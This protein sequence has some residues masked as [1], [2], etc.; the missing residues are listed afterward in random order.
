MN[1]S[2]NFGSSW[3]TRTMA[4]FSRR[5]MTH[6]VIVTAVAM[7]RGCPFRQLSPKKSPVRLARVLL[8][9]ANFGKEGK[10]ETVIAKISQETLA[11]MVGTTRSR[12][13]LFM[14]EFRKLGF[15]EYNGSLEVHNSLLNVV[16]HDNPH[17]RR[18]ADEDE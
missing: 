16:L 18:R 15:I 17:L 6:S 11:E 4:A 3:S 8:L 9:L 7:R 13:S 1:I 2:E 5:M 14:N 12:V 10:P